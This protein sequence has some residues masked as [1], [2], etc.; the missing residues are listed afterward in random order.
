MRVEKVQLLEDIGAILTESDFVFLITYKGLTVAD[1]AEFRNNLADTNANCHVLKNRLIKK[2]AEKAG[3]EEFSKLEFVGD[4]ALI[5][6]KGDPGAVAKVISAFGKKCDAVAPK[7][8]Y[9]DGAIL[10]EGDVK[11]IASLPSKEILLSQ[12]LG[13]LEAPARN[14]VGVLNTKAT[15]ILNV[16]N[17]YKNKIE[18]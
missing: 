16:L 12:L 17:A 6:G 4:T 3:L 2:A 8:G 1:F 18:N 7:S 5:S 11:A 9:L 14:L 15:E 10:T 13:V